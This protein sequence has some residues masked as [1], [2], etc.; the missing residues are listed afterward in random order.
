MNNMYDEQIRE[1]LTVVELTD[2]ELDEVTGAWDG[3]FGPFFPYN[4]STSLAVTS[5][6]FTTNNNNSWW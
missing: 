1:D 6:A 4:N 5:I 3:G 2:K